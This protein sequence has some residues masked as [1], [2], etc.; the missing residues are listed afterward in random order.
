MLIPFELNELWGYMNYQKKIVVEPEYEEAF[1][2]YNSVGR[3]KKNGKYGYIDNKGKLIVKPKYDYAE[4]FK[5]GVTKVRRGKKINF[6]DTKGRKFTGYIGNCG[7]HSD[8]RAPTILN[9]SLIATKR[10]SILQKAI[11]NSIISSIDSIYDINEILFVAKK[12][13]KIAIIEDSPVYR[14]VDSIIFNIRY[15]YDSIKYFSCNFND[16]GIKNHIGIKIKELWGY[17][18]FNDWPTQ[19][20]EPKY[21][22]IGSFENEFARV[23]FEPNR[24]GYIDLQGN[25]YFFRKH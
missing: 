25:E 7:Y 12:N 23:E 19:K 3:I 20:I 14:H 16:G 6:I 21:L 5:S 24:F 17:F 4:D 22:S 15:E 11:L 13:N 8:F 18:I 9:D 2:T 10:Y 1:I